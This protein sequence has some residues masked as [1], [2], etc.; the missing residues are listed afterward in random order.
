MQQEKTEK[1]ESIGQVLQNSLQVSS[2]STPQEVEKSCRNCGKAVR[3]GEGHF[4]VSEPFKHYICK[5]C[6]RAKD[7]RRTEELR[8]NRKYKSELCRRKIDQTIPAYFRKAHLRHFNRNFV[9]LLLSA[10]DSGVVLYGD[11]GRGK[12]YALSALARYLICHGKDYDDCYLIKR[13]TYDMLCMEIRSTYAKNS[14]QS[15][16]DIIQEYLKYKYLII[17][18]VGTSKSIGENESDFSLRTFL[19]ILDQRIEQ[20]KPTFISTNKSRENLEKSFGE[21]IASRLSLFTWIGVG[22]Q[23]KRRCAVKENH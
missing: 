11:T 13:V 9:E 3:A 23:D 15:E 4:V 17:E 14:T 12:T 10:A 7:R 21:R 2:S 22:G 16:Y 8:K 5:D 19:I 20:Q 6:K 1:I 18:D